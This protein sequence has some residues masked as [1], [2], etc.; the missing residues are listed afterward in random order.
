MAS[1]FPELNLTEDEKALIFV[2]RYK[3]KFGEVTILVREGIPYRILKAFEST[4]LG[5][6][7]SIRKLSST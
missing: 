1:I 3:Y 6:K 5:D 4:D 7:D 2:L